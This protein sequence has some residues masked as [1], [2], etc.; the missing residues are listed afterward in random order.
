MASQAADV[1][2][3]TKTLRIQELQLRYINAKMKQSL[4]IRTAKVRY[5]H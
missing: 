5:E 4:A 3:E 2:S 1:R